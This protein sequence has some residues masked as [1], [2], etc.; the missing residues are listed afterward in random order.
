MSDPFEGQTPSADEVPPTAEDPG[1]A[2]GLQS[3]EDLD[4]DELG[5]DPLEE[6]V[7]PPENWSVVTRDRRTPS[8]DHAGETLDERLAEE[9]ST[10]ADDLDKPLAETR[11][12]ELDET[13]DERAAAEVT[14]GGVDEPLAAA[15]DTETIGT[16][17]VLRGGAEEPTG[18]A[19]STRD[20]VEVDDEPDTEGPEEA[21]ERVED[22]GW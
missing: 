18:Y 10:A 22:S 21:A 1:D 9:R 7:E 8:E 14:D 6:G 16:G 17:A 11:M 3:A 20:G 4:E 2:A 5:V 12:F 13:V 15:P 19:S